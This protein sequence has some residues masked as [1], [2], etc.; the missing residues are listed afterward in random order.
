MDTNTTSR[1]KKLLLLF[2]IAILTSCNQTPYDQIIKREYYNTTHIT[3]NGVTYKIIR[4]YK[5]VSFKVLDSTLPEV[6]VEHTYKCT[7]VYPICNIVIPNCTEID[8]VYL[9]KNKEGRYEFC[10][11][12]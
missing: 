11:S 2:I 7:L 4:D 3:K 5:P 6:A 8:T 9:Y 1:M 10:K 12:K